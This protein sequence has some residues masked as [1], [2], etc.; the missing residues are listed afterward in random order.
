[1][2]LLGGI[3]AVEERMLIATTYNG[4]QPEHTRSAA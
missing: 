1:M 3:L 2:V 4:C